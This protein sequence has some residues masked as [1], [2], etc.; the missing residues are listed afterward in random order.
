MRTKDQ[1]KEERDKIVKG[2][3]EAYRSLIEY[4]IR[5]RSKLIITKNGEIV[6]LSPE[7]ANEEVKYKRGE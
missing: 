4:K 1:L 7:K 5:V 3:E 2:L 6:A